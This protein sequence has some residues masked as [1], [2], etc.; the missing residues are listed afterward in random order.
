MDVHAQTQCRTFTR[1]I[2]AKLATAPGQ[3][4]LQVNDIA[5]DLQDGRLLI[6]LLNVLAPEAALAPERN[7]LRIHKVINVGKVLSY[8]QAHSMREQL[9]NIGA[10]DIVDGNLKLTL[11]LIWMLI[12][13]FQMADLTFTEQRR[14]SVSSVDMDGI[15]QAT[16]AL[17]LDGEDSDASSSRA[18]SL[19]IP[20][21]ERPSLV[22]PTTTPPADATLDQP[23]KSKK[24]PKQADPKSVLLR[25]V[26]HR[27]A[28]SPH[29]HMYTP[30]HDF[31]RAWQDGV[32]FCLLVDSIDSSCINWDQVRYPA[33]ET[34]D[35]H[36]NLTLAFN[37]ASSALN[38]PQLLD[39]VDVVSAGVPDEKSIMTYVSSFFVHAKSQPAGPVAQPQATAPL[40][41][42]LSPFLS[43]IDKHLNDIAN[44][45]H[46]DPANIQPKLSAVAA[47]PA[48]GAT[49]QARTLLDSITSCLAQCHERPA[50][51]ISAPVLQK[52]EQYATLSR[53][54]SELCVHLDNTLAASRSCASLSASLQDAITAIS[55]VEEHAAGDEDWKTRDKAMS[56]AQQ[57]AKTAKSSLQ[58]LLE[59]CHEQQLPIQEPVGPCVELA[60]SIEQVKSQ[61]DALGIGIKRQAHYVKLGQLIKDFYEDCDVCQAW[62]VES[63][64][65]LRMKHVPPFSASQ[66]KEY[67]AFISDLQRWCSIMDQHVS[68]FESNTLKS[69]EATAENI[70]HHVQRAGSLASPDTRL[71]VLERSSAITVQ[72]TQ[73]QELYTQ[74]KT[75]LVS[76]ADI[77]AFARRALSLDST[78]KTIS[79]S[80]VWQEQDTAA[81]DDDGGE[82]YASS[83]GRTQAPSKALVEAREQ[84]DMCAN[85]IAQLRKDHAA[86]L[87]SDLNAQRYQEYLENMA[88]TML[89]PL[90]TA[91]K[92]NDRMTDVLREWDTI[93]AYARDIRLRMP[94]P[95]FLDDANAAAGS[96]DVSATRLVDLRQLPSEYASSCSSISTLAGL[97]QSYNIHF[98]QRT[99]LAAQEALSAEPS[100]PQVAVVKQKRDQVLADWQ[101][102]T[103]HVKKYQS[104]FDTFR[105]TL[106]FVKSCNAI[107]HRMSLIKAALTSSVSSPVTPT[108]SLG[109]ARRGSA[110]SALSLSSNAGSGGSTLNLESCREM[111][112]ALDGD[113]AELKVRYP[114]VVRYRDTARRHEAICQTLAD[115]NNQ[116]E[117]S[118]QME[119]LDNTR[120]ELQGQVNQLHTAIAEYHAMVKQLQDRVAAA[121]SKSLKGP[122]KDELQLLKSDIKATGV[123]LNRFGGK[124][125]SLQEAIARLSASGSTPGVAMLQNSRQ[126]LEQQFRNASRDLV[127]CHADVEAM[128]LLVAFNYTLSEFAIH[129]S[130]AE[131]ALLRDTPHTVSTLLEQLSNKTS[132]LS[133]TFRVMLE[134]EPDTRSRL[135]RFHSRVEVLRA[136]HDNLVHAEEVTAA[137]NDM[138]TAVSSK[139]LFSLTTPNDFT[140]SLD[141]ISA[142]TAVQVDLESQVDALNEG[143][144]RPYFAV[145][146]K[147]L[148]QGSDEVAVL[149]PRITRHKTAAMEMFMQIE[150]KI[151]VR[152][153]LLDFMQRVHDTTQ[154]AQRLQTELASYGQQ[155]EFVADNAG[156]EQL[157]AKA[158][159][160]RAE[161]DN[162]YAQSSDLRQVFVPFDTLLRQLEQETQAFATRLTQV[163]GSLAASDKRK[164]ADDQLAR[165]VSNARLILGSLPQLPT[166]NAFGVADAEYQALASLVSAVEVSLADSE[167][168]FASASSAARAAQVEQS[169]L[170]SAQSDLAQVQNEVRQLR[171]SLQ[172][173][174]ALRQKNK[175][176]QGLRS[177]LTGLEDRLATV[178]SLSVLAE[179]QSELQS[180][181]LSFRNY[182]ASIP[183]KIAP[184]ATLQSALVVFGE[185]LHAVEERID[186]QKGRLQFDQDFVAFDKA[187]ALVR[188]TLSQ[189]Q[190]DI[191]QADCDLSALETRLEG[192]VTTD[193][194]NLE[195]VANA[196]VAFQTHPPTRMRMESVLQNVLQAV[197]SIQTLLQSARNDRHVKDKLNVYLTSASELE[198]SMKQQTTTLSNLEARLKVPTS[199]SLS[200]DAIADAGQ[201]LSETT[202]LLTQLQQR[203]SE[204]HAVRSRLDLTAKK[205][206]GLPNLEAAVSARQATLDTAWL[207][208]AQRVKAVEQKAHSAQV[209][210]EARSV[211][212]SVQD[213][214]EDVISDID[215]LTPDAP[216]ELSGQYGQRLTELASEAEQHEAAY[217]SADLTVEYALALSHVLSD[218]SSRF[219]TAK[220]RLSYKRS[221]IAE[222][223]AVRSFDEQ[224]QS[225][226][227]AAAKIQRTLQE[228]L[229]GNQ[230][231]VGQDGNGLTELAQLQSS[232][233][234]DMSA[235]SDAQNRLRDNADRVVTART[236]R[237]N[238]KLVRSLALLEES[239]QQLTS[240]AATLNN[241]IARLNGL[242]RLF[243]EVS[244]AD[245]E[246][247]QL[248]KTLQQAQHSGDESVFPQIERL[249]EPI[250]A[251]KTT[252][253]AAYATFNTEYQRN[254]QAQGT[255]PERAAI[256][257]FQS[258]FLTVSEHCD[259]VEATHATLVYAM[260]KAGRLLVMLSDLEQWCDIMEEACQDRIG[261]LR[262][263]SVQSMT[264]VDAESFIKGAMGVAN[265][266]ESDLNAHQTQLDKANK[267]FEQ[268]RASMSSLSSTLLQRI[269]DKLRFAHNA[270]AVIRQSFVDEN[271]V[272]ELLR[273]VHGHTR[274]SDQIMVWL[275]AAKAAIVFREDTPHTKESL[276]EA[277]QKL[278]SFAST[279]DKF[280]SVSRDLQTT[281]ASAG[282]DNDDLLRHVHERT[283]R[284]V[285]EWER[286]RSTVEHMQ[287]S[288][289]M[290]QALLEFEKVATTLGRMID[291]YQDRVVALQLDSGMRDSNSEV[292]LRQGKDQLHKIQIE[293]QQII[294]PKIKLVDNLLSRISSTEQNMAQTYQQRDAL[295]QSMQQLRDM[296]S[297]KIALV[298]ERLCAISAMKLYDEVAQLVSSC[299]AMVSETVPDTVPLLEVEPT[300]NSIDARYKNYSSSITRLL[301]MADNYTSSLSEQELE[302]VTLRQDMVRNQWNTV[303]HQVS[304][305]KRNLDLRKRMLMLRLERSRDQEPG[306]PRMSM[307]PTSPPHHNNGGTYLPRS[308][309]PASSAG[310]E[311]YHSRIPSMAS[312]SSS[313]ILRPKTPPASRLLAP[314]LLT[315]TPPPPMPSIT[316]SFTSPT[317][318]YPLVSRRP[319]AAS[320]SGGY[321]GDSTM[322][323]DAMPAPRPTRYAPMLDSS[324]QQSLRMPNVVVYH[325]DP[326]DEVDV[327]VAEVVNGLGVYIPVKRVG[328]GKY[329]FGQIDAKVMN[330]RLVRRNVLVRVGGG[331]RGLRE[332]LLE[333]SEFFQLLVK[334]ESVLPSSSVYNNG[335]NG[336]AHPA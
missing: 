265:N 98:V 14:G 59:T 228:T 100:H 86:V 45:L 101:A 219:A 40:E 217:A 263:A 329:Q 140:P 116:I 134:R 294:A 236:V 10:E 271:G 80:A 273:K 293:M 285:G 124:L 31:T 103:D 161:I 41:E 92:R 225:C 295:N 330:C 276:K 193:V 52:L 303:Q 185:R 94:P 327:H 136:I 197:D 275:T 198:L 191:A 237:D 235:L 210:A 97:V 256:G 240:L 91:P 298:D 206:A 272:I 212:A 302:H 159:Q 246:L 247:Q 268:Q 177:S 258:R 279:V 213:A 187:A 154:L 63:L 284:T 165:A 122:S 72:W 324:D 164:H 144:L 231:H 334:N 23:K 87:S 264:L 109:R 255:A 274:A 17:K 242:Q 172:H 335:H 223:A 190:A 128:E 297:S 126:E 325:P 178:S 49:D 176:L 221:T 90:S 166:D 318:A 34:A 333:S 188:Q 232:V 132:A 135:M 24:T 260:S 1:W 95:L 312:S 244:K 230:P 248:E 208:L 224:Y 220:E 182:K 81:H 199:L 288:L 129:A 307:L 326:S 36:Y 227:D 69:L 239:W 203:V 131:D 173:I 319:S 194:P 38:L 234:A 202:E 233:K 189:M 180:L 149:A 170:V 323:M 73:L 205:C 76:A 143:K 44:L 169:K 300:V 287:K 226:V 127:R 74:L 243:A 336:Y 309:S 15:S 123:H 266:A 82:D 118:Y 316:P 196:T 85:G 158:D 241:S 53:G 4:P 22:S 27:L 37:A 320:T 152:K 179:I 114:N 311:G 112:R 163:R 108:G 70:C 65:S 286:M 201:Q 257:Q 61:I 215:L 296:V 245:T 19:D 150:E 218:L 105:W 29:T 290:E 291:H 107:E 28:K 282:S 2:N 238:A 153:G 125:R 308:V 48:E 141:D 25:W 317:S 62:I 151:D 222:S 204:M 113:V 133:S 200:A 120:D 83:I 78:L 8:L 18:S 67:I 32:A 207:L 30:V 5:Q 47:L 68:E 7:S 332:H 33:Q 277:E 195:A 12:L 328:P 269:D 160:A 79:Q 58:S 299:N 259:A 252:L 184:D 42:D 321:L 174:Q 111:V 301:D 175:E 46:L 20:A 306:I 270:I 313:G 305:L 278:A 147:L 283:E 102:L 229:Y 43:Q 77:A 209:L 292:Q 13:R 171:A 84:V 186:Q 35:W 322:E 167:L 183:A 130:Q 216:A 54:I 71:K 121:K 162:V 99:S 262:S 51:A 146:N 310:G 304:E 60:T 145:T 64:S 280:R 57:V 139:P 168:E 155:L 110:S 89:Q 331:W 96:T 156:L 251:A 281:L 115:I 104:T 253:S 3:P 9:S 88:A 21:A 211:L 214:V 50:A 117:T 39:P 137:L 66:G 11:G 56:A 250:L 181:H 75:R 138:S 16:R 314:R 267:E 6:A 157:G 249:G 26:N 106:D 93:A 55:Q 148:S 192:V 254:S 315:K 289:V 119:E 142:A 261:T